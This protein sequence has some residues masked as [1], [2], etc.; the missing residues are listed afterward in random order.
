MFQIDIWQEQCPHSGVFENVPAAH[1]ADV[2]VTDESE[3][4]DEEEEEE[5]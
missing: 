1:T 3:E 2:V 4:D 5:Q